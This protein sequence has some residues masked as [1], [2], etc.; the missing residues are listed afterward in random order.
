[1]ASDEYNELD[2]V[3]DSALSGYSAQEPWP[4]IEDRILNRIRNE[5]ARRLFA[6]FRWRAVLAG[7]AGCLLLA[8]VLFRHA[9]DPSSTALAPVPPRPIEP[10]RAELQAATAAQ[11]PRPRPRPESTRNR[12]IAERSPLPKRQVFPTPSP[13][14]AEERALL[15]VISRGPERVRETLTY[16]QTSVPKPI[17]IEPIEI[18]ELQNS[19]Q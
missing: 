8:A 15:A 2:K 14:T 4:G 5:G 18:Q 3:L 11:E 17:Q 1:M 12:Q 10:P 16:A 9:A 7:A 13:L 6:A 19:P